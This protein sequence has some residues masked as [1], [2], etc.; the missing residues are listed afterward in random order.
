MRGRGQPRR[1]RFLDRPGQGAAA[2]WTVS[3]AVDDGTLTS[4]SAVSFPAATLCIA[5]DFD[6]NT[7]AGA[8]HQLTVDLAGTGSGT[9]TTADGS[10]SCSPVCSSIYPPA[11]WSP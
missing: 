9:V 6:G 7:L 5:A 4:V 11:R 3:A 10:I 1:H 2:T 8:G